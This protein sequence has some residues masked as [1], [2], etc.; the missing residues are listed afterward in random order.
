MLQLSSW[1]TAGQ[2]WTSSTGSTAVS[3]LIKRFQAEQWKDQLT[4]T[5]CLETSWLIIFSWYFDLLQENHRSISG[6]LPEMD[7]AYLV[8]TLLRVVAWNPEPDPEH[9]LSWIKLVGTKGNH[10]V[11]GIW[12]LHSG[13][14]IMTWTFTGEGQHLPFLFF[15]L[16]SIGTFPPQESSQDAREVIRD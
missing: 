8:L 3:A 4:S 5:F 12:T 9:S 13:P 15:F 1:R 10:G 7:G 2:G 11:L 14:L 16:H 6:P